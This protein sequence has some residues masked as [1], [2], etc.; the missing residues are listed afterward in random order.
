MTK[1]NIDSNSSNNS[2]QISSSSQSESNSEDTNK[3]PEKGGYGNPDAWNDIQQTTEQT[4]A[5]QD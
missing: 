1:V 3:S 5:N 4:A 2:Q